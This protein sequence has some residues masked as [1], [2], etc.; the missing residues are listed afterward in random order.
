MTFNGYIDTPPIAWQLRGITNIM[1]ERWCCLRCGVL[2]DYRQYSG[3]LLGRVTATDYA[4]VAADSGAG[5]R[6]DG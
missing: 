3:I 4:R 6:R 2:F 5:A 1:A